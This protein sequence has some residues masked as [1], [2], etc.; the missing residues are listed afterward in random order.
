MGKFIRQVFKIDTFNLVECTDGYYLWDTVIG[1]NIAT[2]AK[3]ERDAYIEAL[4]H[5]QRRYDKLRNEYNI[6]DA[7]VESFLSQFNEDED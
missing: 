3:T 1:Y 6:L 5:Y 4:L 7:K 2:H